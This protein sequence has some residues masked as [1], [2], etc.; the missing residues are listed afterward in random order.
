M[1]KLQ[2]DEIIA[3]VNIVKPKKKHEPK[4]K[5]EKFS[6]RERLGFV[7]ASTIVSLVGVFILC[8]LVNIWADFTTVE[9]AVLSGVTVSIVLILL[10]IRGW[11]ARFKKDMKE[12]DISRKIAGI[13]KLNKHITKNLPITKY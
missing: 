7:A 8:S 12:D 11:L 4:N 6:K 1:S 13:I 9:L 3:C 2:N 5:P 10:R